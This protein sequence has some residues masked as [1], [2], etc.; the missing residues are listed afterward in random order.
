MD[1][2]EFLGWV[3]VGGIVSFL[4]VAI[5]ACTPQTSSSEAAGN[6]PA[7]GG[8]QPVGTVTDLNK[9]GQILAQHAAGGPVLVVRKPNDPNALAAV[10]PICTHAGCTVNW[11][12][13]QDKFV[14]PC[15]GS[16]FA[17]DG[18]VL[19]GPAQK[20]LPVYTAKIEGDQV[21]VQ[22]S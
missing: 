1:R 9:D 19:Q 8:F 12:Q 11:M 21:L 2:R 13:D 6:P 14:C 17:I 7:S 10:S 20:P 18:K 22:E 3:G 15:H 16:Q 4:P 5:A